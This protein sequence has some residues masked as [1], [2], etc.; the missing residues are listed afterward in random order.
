[1]HMG[2]DSLAAYY[3]LIGMRVNVHTHTCKKISGLDGFVP[4]Y[5]EQFASAN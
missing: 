1:M 4:G 2:L 5:C 3:V